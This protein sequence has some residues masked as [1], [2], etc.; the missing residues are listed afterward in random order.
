MIFLNYFNCSIIIVFSGMYKELGGGHF[1]KLLWTTQNRKIFKV[2]KKY[3]RLYYM[4]QQSDVVDAVWASFQN[5]GLKS[6]SKPPSPS[7]P[8]GCVFILGHLAANH[9]LESNQGKWLL[10]AH[11]L[12][13]GR[14]MTFAKSEIS[15]Y[16]RSYFPLDLYVWLCVYTFP[17]SP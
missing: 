12:T 11:R 8:P 10:K 2:K 15:K 5:S 16:P 6:L 14:K 3:S 1:S 4:I 13:G 7:R 17:P 9:D